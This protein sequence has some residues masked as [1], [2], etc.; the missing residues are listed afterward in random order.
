MA[1][2]KQV[3]I[4]FAVDAK[5][6]QDAR[7]AIRALTSDVQKLV[8]TMGRAGAGMGSLLGGVSGK[9]GAINTRQEAI[10][11]PNV[12][13]SLAGSI[14]KDAQALGQVA[15]AGSSAMDQ[16][17]RSLKSNF[18]G[19]IQ[20]IDRLNSKLDVLKQKYDKMRE[21]GAG[22]GGAYPPVF[23]RDLH[24][25]ELAQRRLQG[26]IDY[27]ESEGQAERERMWSDSWS[28]SGHRKIKIPQG[29]GPT[30][31]GDDSG[32][33]SGGV[34][35]L[36]QQ[37][38]VPGGVAKMAGG[39]WGAIGAG[40]ALATN[41]HN[42]TQSSDTANAAYRLNL[43]METGRNASR[44]G[45]SVGAMQMAILGGSAS[46]SAAFT[47][48]MTDGSIAR[49]LGNSQNL[50]RSELR[51]EASGASSL[52][53][54]I[55]AA[56]AAELSNTLGR[57]GLGGDR[58]Q[59]LGV[60]ESAV[61]LK[62]KTLLRQLNAEK[63]EQLREM[64][65][66]ERA[67][68]PRSTAYLD[69][70]FGQTFGVVGTSRLGGRAMGLNKQAQIQATLQMP[71]E[72]A[73]FMLP[74][75]NTLQGEHEQRSMHHGYS[76]AEIDAARFSLGGVAGR[77]LMG[78]GMT[79]LSAGLGGFSN[80]GQVIGAGAQF[81][82][83]M[84]LYR[85]AQAGMGRGGVD[86]TA[87][88]QLSGYITSAMQNGN[89]VGGTGVEAM[90][91]I[92]AAGAT[93]STGGDMRMARILGAGMGQMDKSL[94][95]GVDPLQGGINMLAANA[96]GASGWYAKK[97]L[98][99]LDTASMLGI[100]RSGNVGALSEEGI[101]LGMV[102]KYNAS[103]NQ[104]T[105][106][107][108]IDQEGAGT[109]VGRSVLGAKRAGSTTA[110]LHSLMAGKSASEQ[111]AIM[112]REIKR[113]G[114][115]AWQAGGADTRESG[116]GQ[117]ALEAAADPTLR[118]ALRASGVGASKMDKLSQSG[119][120]AAAKLDADFT[121]DMALR[122]NQ[123]KT[124]FDGMDANQVVL[125]GIMKGLVKDGKD[126][127]TV[128]ETATNALL[129]ALMKAAPDEALRIAKGRENLLKEIRAT[130]VP[131]KGEGRTGYVKDEPPPRT[132]PAPPIGFGGGKL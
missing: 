110:Y 43:G 128:L 50:N 81:G 101:N 122:Y 119:A 26:R 31:G 19:Q 63:A 113:L 109:D 65:E 86:A 74:N 42:M 88:S 93:G 124:V 75:M 123:M 118:K 95:G 96:S 126:F 41:I 52:S 90:Q 8:E 114:T 17:T 13:S 14:T 64:L 82:P 58:R 85:A 9:T 34:A 62:N 56:G 70:A 78:H 77:G 33:G 117:I 57:Y 16:L 66:N 72:L 49:Q 39:R 71:G 12:G 105:F 23:Y 107:R 25:N 46:T 125:G 29:T 108:Y 73:K 115:G 54:A 6:L 28:S 112:S 69:R 15:R 37:L 48:L 18:S 40:I 55:G 97:S 68:D 130:A 121:K 1:D 111:A 103:R 35:A 44:I 2:S 87:G 32:G 106:S 21:A 45:N 84:G 131:P 99:G 3:K 89:F 59:G 61:E 91:G 120:D 80:A 94:S 104:H 51:N 30:P 129:H 60:T 10:K 92:M 53:G 4:A 11:L 132:T 5:G 38:G 127:E 83:A 24:R 22:G 36:L 20:D 100:L 67:S 27:R 47:K 7:N 98:M 79:V 76:G 116:I 102:Q